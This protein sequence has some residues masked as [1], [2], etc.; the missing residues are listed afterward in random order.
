MKFATALLVLGAAQAHKFLGGE[1]HLLTAEDHEFIKFVAKYGKSYGTKAEF[2]FRAEQFKQ[3]LAKVE[4]HN[5]QNGTSTVGINQFSDLTDSEW[6]RMLGYKNSKRVMAA[7]PK[8]LPTENL[9]AEV[10]W[11]DQGA[12]TPVKN[13][14]MCGS[15]WAFSTTGAVEG[16]E[17]LST[18]TL[19]SFSEQQ[20][21][22]CAGGQWGNYGCN[23]GLMDLAFQYV[24][25]NPLQL[26]ATYAYT[27]VDGTCL[28]DATKGV[29]KVVGFADV[30]PNSSE[31]LKAALQNGPVSVAIEADQF[32]FQGYTGGVITSG[33]GQNL[34]HGVLAVGYGTENGTEY[35]LVKNSWGASWGVNGYVKIGAGSS[36]VCGILSSASYPTE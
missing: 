13:Q 25:S 15:C 26:E 11:V 1:S 29:G 12:V 28:Y 17:F 4:E 10:N 35:F 6:K 9:A 2:A 24:E 31:Q 14:G 16:A 20:L 36:N 27:G 5:S 32:A 22:D 3:A 21:V 33:C 34:D 23:G 18:G 19:S 30:T 7:E 8:V